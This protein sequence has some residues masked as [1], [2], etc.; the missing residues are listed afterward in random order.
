MLLVGFFS[1]WYGPGWRNQLTRIGESLVKV[2]D[3]FSI[4]L[5][6]KTLFAPFRQISADATGRDIGSK[7]RAWGDRMFS[8]CIGAFMRTFMI[9]FG[10]IVMLLTLIASLARLALWPIFPIMPVLGLILMVT[11]GAPWKI[12]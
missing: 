11:I 6:A 1:W 2:N 4:P 3:Y 8:R 7:F 5:L 10:I 12:I 9:I